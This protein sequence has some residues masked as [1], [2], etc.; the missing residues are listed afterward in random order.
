MKLPDS[1]PPEEWLPPLFFHLIKQDRTNLTL[2]FFDIAGENCSNVEK[3]NGPF[4]KFVEHSDGM[5][6]L[7]SPNQIKRDKDVKIENKDTP[8]ISDIINTIHKYYSSKTKTN[9]TLPTAVCISKGDI[10]QKYVLGKSK[11]LEDVRA[12]KDGKS[13]NSLEYNPLNNKIINFI[14]NKTEQDIRTIMNGYES[15]S[16]FILSALGFEPKELK[17]TYE[18]DGKKYQRTM[19]NNEPNPKRIIEPVAWLL[20]KFGFIGDYN[21]W[22]C[23]YCKKESIPDS[24]DTCPKCLRRRKDGFWNCPK[25]GTPNKPDTQVCCTCHFD[26]EK[27]TYSGFMARLREWLGKKL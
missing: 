16:F 20:L 15:F 12:A 25:C 18:V 4:G 11:E 8:L 3:M 22:T 6:I 7:F 24:N 13:F 26:P 1:T 14:N 23:K 27:G 2:V 5:I 10:I 17:E 19:I 9:T 21:E